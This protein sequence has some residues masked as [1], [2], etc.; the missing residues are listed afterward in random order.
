MIGDYENGLDLISKSIQDEPI[1]VGFEESLAHVV[2]LQRLNHRNAED[3]LRIVLVAEPK[4][5][6]KDRQFTI[7]G[8]ILFALVLA[9]FDVPVQGLSAER[10]GS[11][12]SKVW[13]QQIL[14]TLPDFQQIRAIVASIVLDY[15][16]QECRDLDALSTG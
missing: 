14:D 8:G 16:F 12:V 15:E 11:H 4:S 9:E 3:K 10:G 13:V 6:P 1:L 5:P 7:D 2:F